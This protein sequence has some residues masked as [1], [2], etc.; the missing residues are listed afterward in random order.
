M[1]GNV[2]EW[3]FEWFSSSYPSDTTD[4]TGASSGSFR[5]ILGGSWSHSNSYCTVS[6]RFNYYQSYEYYSIG[7]RLAHD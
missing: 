2:W 6:N 7:C 5:V 3:C 1:S 4:Y